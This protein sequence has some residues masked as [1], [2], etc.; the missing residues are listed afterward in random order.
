MSLID[1]CKLLSW[2]KGFSHR[3]SLRSASWN[4]WVLSLGR[5]RSW[6]ELCC[7]AALVIY[8]ITGLC[9]IAQAADVSSSASH[10]VRDEKITQRLSGVQRTVKRHMELLDWELGIMVFSVHYQH[11][12][13]AV[14][15]N[16][17][18]RAHFTGSRSLKQSA[19]PSICLFMTP[20][21]P[22]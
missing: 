4:A 18:S 17:P 8:F 3:L 22:C 16:R 7:L 20:C 1:W 14:F 9:N 5:V 21:L 15:V 10:G 19:L 2:R 13:V 6:I 12:E 11:W